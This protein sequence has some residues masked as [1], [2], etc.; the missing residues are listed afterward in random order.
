MKNNLVLAVGVAL[1]VGFASGGAV[2]APYLY[3]TVQQL[4]DGDAETLLNA[5]GT[6]KAITSS[7]F[8]QVGD[9]FG[10]VIKIQQTFPVPAGTPEINLQSGDTFT[11]FFL[12][13]TKS[14]VSGGDATTADGTNDQIFFGA[15]TQSQ[16]ST[17]FGAGGAIDISSVLDVSNING[18]GSGI[19]SGTMALMFNGVTYSSAQF[20][21][22]GTMSGSATSFISGGTLQYEFG[23]TGTDGVAAA[24]QFWKTTG[25]D[26]TIPSL[27]ITNDLINRL[28]LDVTRQWAG[29][30]LA[31]HNYLLS[32]GDA[33]YTG[34]TQFQGKGNFEQVLTGSPWALQTDSDLFISPVPEPSALALISLGLMGLGWVGRRTS[35][36]V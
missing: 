33:N 27:A 23:F 25:I 14:I 34:A 4:E 19:A 18:T 11:A 16:W 15:A 3:N 24:N 5:D 10:G 22:G 2:A 9:L 32:A 35:K 20:E 8:I 31:A 13:D 28:A 26:A 17:V 6:V 30:D 29:P 36:R 12:I 7:S 21:A 1:A